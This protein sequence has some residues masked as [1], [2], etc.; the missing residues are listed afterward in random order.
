MK[1]TLTTFL[2]LVG[3]AAFADG[4]TLVCDEL[5]SKLTL[6]T[7]KSSWEIEGEILYNKGKDGEYGS[8]MVL[9]CKSQALD[10]EWDMILC[11]ETTY[12]VY[13]PALQVP[14]N[15][16]STKQKTPFEITY[17]SRDEN[18]AKIY[19]SETFKNCTVQ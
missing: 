9:G 17:L 1:N 5:D 15:V 3:S 18:D 7:N 14:K 19:N 2:F 12:S 6:S 10:D 13:G 11:D 16:F 4:K 8:V